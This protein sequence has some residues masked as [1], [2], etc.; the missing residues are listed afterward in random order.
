MVDLAPLLVEQLAD[1]A[2]L[3]SNL[4]Q[5]MKTVEEQIPEVGC[6][7]LVRIARL[8][9]DSSRLCGQLRQ[10][11]AEVGE[12]CLGQRQHIRDRAIPGEREGLVAA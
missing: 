2:L 10:D 8:W 12:G 3:G 7:G 5:V 1:A 6:V 4:F 9:A 11:R